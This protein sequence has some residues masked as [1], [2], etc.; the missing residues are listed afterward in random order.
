MQDKNEARNSKADDEF[1]SIL[2]KST[3]IRRET[4]SPIE[5]QSFF[6]RRGAT[7]LAH[8]D[9]IGETFSL[10]IN[11][12]RCIS[13]CFQLQDQKYYTDTFERYIVTTKEG[14]TLYT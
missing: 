12:A 6:G 2:S 7:R 14:T 4:S 3:N 5:V 8:W 13:C 11:E 10:G 9:T 1:W